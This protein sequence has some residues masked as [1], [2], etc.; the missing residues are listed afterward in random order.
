[1]PTLA[2]LDRE[3]AVGVGLPDGDE[4]AAVALLATA[5]CTGVVFLVAGFAAVVVVEGAL[6][7]TGF[8]LRLFTF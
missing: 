5:E 3:V 1:M 4:C 8:S 2:E 6:P 7:Q